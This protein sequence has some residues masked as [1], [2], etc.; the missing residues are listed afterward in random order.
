[1]NMLLVIAIGSTSC[2]TI[3]TK[4]SYPITFTSTPSGAD[5]TIENRAGKTIYTGSTPSTVK[6]KA[7]AGY[8]KKEEYSVTFQKSGLPSKTV[9]V[10]CNLD[11]WYVGNILIGGLIGM[12]IVDPASG[13]MYKFSETEVHVDLGGDTAQLRELRIVDISQVPEGVELVRI[14]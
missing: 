7:A 8:M 12:L 6:L 4:S 1:M 14:N 10:I 5:I 9:P 13:A 2:A 11:G 3:F